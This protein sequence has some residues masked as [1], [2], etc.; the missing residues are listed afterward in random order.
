ML[1]IGG[2]K[3]SSKGITIYGTLVFNF[4]ETYFWGEITDFDQ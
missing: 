1:V 3:S 4:E 2:F